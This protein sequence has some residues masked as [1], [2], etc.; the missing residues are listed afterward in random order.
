MILYFWYFFEIA[1]NMISFFHEY[2]VISRHLH[3]ANPNTNVGYLLE[4]ERIC[5]IRMVNS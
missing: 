4:Q 3:V 2:D 1:I 5:E